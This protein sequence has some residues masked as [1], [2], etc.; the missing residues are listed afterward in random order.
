MRNSD[1]WERSQ[2]MLFT[3]MFSEECSFFT[4]LN[5]KKWSWPWFFHHI[6]FLAPWQFSRIN[7]PAC[8]PCGAANLGWP[9]MWSMYECTPE[10]II[11]IINWIIIV[12]N[13]I[14][15]IVITNVVSVI[16]TVFVIFIVR[17]TCNFS[18]LSFSLSLQ[19][20]SSFVMRRKNYYF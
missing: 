6:S 7:R 13:V 16:V 11:N 14:V 20:K 19:L 8:R 2:R 4:N 10:Y 3:G 15:V 18:W 12:V 5:T 17:V 9:S 1:L